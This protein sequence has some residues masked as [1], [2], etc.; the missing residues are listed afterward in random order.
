[1]KNLLI[2]LI[3]LF[4][5]QIHGQTFYP[6]RLFDDGKIVKSIIPTLTKDNSGNIYVDIPERGYGLTLQE[7]N[8]FSDAF[9]V[10][11]QDGKV[12]KVDLGKHYVGKI[13]GESNTVAALSIYND[14]LICSF[15]DQEGNWEITS[16][17]E[18]YQLRQ[19]PLVSDDLGECYTS[20]EVKHESPVGVESGVCRTVQIY[21]EADYKLYQDK[22]SNVQNVTTYVTALFTQIAALYLNESINVQIS[23]LKVWAAPDPYIPFSSISSVLN[24]FRNDLGTSFSGNL[25]HLLSTRSLGGGIAYVDVLCTK[26]FAFG[27]SAIT[28]SFQNV[29]T[30]SWSVEVVT[31]ELGHNLGSWHTHSCNWPNGAL[32]NCRSP[33]GSCQPGP[34]PVNGGTIMSYCHLTSHG[35][36][37]ANGFG[38]V[39]GNHIRGKYNAAGC[40]TGSGSSPTGLTVTNLTSTSVKLNWNAVPGVASYE[41][42]YKKNSSSIWNVSANLVGLSL[43]LGGLTPSTLYDWK[44]KTNCSGFSAVQNFTTLSTGNGCQIITGL[45]VTNITAS[46]ATINWQPI[47]G[48]T[49]YILQFKELNQ[50]IWQ[51]VN[52]II[53]TSYQ[54]SQLSA[55]TNY[56]VKVRANC[57]NTFSAEVQFKSLIDNPTCPT[58]YDLKTEII[59]SAWV[60]ISWK[61]SIVGDKYFLGI[62]LASQIQWFDL[63]PVAITS[64]IISG[65]QPNTTYNWRVR[66]QCSAW[67]Q[68]MTFT[69]LNFGPTNTP[70]GSIPFG[71]N[72]YPNPT[73]D[74]LNVSGST[75]KI[76][77][78]LGQ[79]QEEGSIQNSKINVSFLCAGIYFLQ[80]DGTWVKFIKQ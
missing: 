4:S 2:S 74:E 17:L 59:T 70:T 30:Y 50:S 40:L 1:M 49:S 24:K 6:I 5:F 71:L 80:V 26:Q 7:V 52:G 65:L 32:D 69:T 62:K 77:N 53:G 42:Q 28:T 3:I 33:E 61:G 23:Q 60:K 46:L 63:G 79:M 48:A 73:S 16:N 55:N 34:T 19:I 20:D 57:N 35:I 41:I 54:I 44:I 29:P 36:N 25:A 64:V 22:G 67:S 39:P 76:F 21:F 11:D 27:V 31:H 10:T 38:P 15:S 8:I 75:F 72:I 58:P 66:S 9:Q 47:S 51:T 14:E 18:T 43:T 78:S 56:L 45:T 68:T 37:F 13:D 12:Q